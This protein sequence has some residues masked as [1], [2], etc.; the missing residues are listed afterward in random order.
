[1][2]K[3][4]VC[5][6]PLQYPAYANNEAIVVV[7]D[8]FRATSAIC[9]AFEYGVEAII[10][11]SSI[12]EAQAYREKGYMVG[13]ERQGQRVEGYELGNSPY[14]YMG[15]N[16]KGKT[17]VLTTTNGTKAIEVSRDAYKVA[18]GSFLNLTAICNWLI[19]QQRDVLLLCAGWKGRF[20]LEDSA[21]A[22]AVCETLAH[23]PSFTNPSDSATAA[24]Q[25]YALAKGD[26]SA[27][28]AESSHRRR[29]QNLQLKKDIEYCLQLDKTNVIPVLD[30]DRL[31]SL[32]QQNLVAPKAKAQ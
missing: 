31:V 4:E 32:H 17:T 30:N 16:I 15:D 26:L 5:F 20:N 14:H 1:M 27:Y 23:S 10:P 25:M 12:E 28:L 7:I 11:V 6:S 9:T 24:A 13:A 19:E 18:I 22:G 21:F 29:L 3:V 2:P 8:I